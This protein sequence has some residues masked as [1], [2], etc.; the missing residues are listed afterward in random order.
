MP[1]IPSFQKKGTPK[2]ATSPLPYTCYDTSPLPKITIVPQKL[3][4]KSVPCKNVLK[5]EMEL[6]ISGQG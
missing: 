1:I 5:L 4:G 6:K 2:N 3:L